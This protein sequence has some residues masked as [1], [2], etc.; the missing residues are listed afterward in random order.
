MAARIFVAKDSAA[1]AV[2]ADEVAE[3]VVTAGRDRGIALDVVRT[4]SRG[5]YW[6]EPMVEAETLAGRVA[7][8]PV[9][10]SDVD[11][12]FDAGFLDGGEHA[13]RLGETEEIPWLK[14]RRG[15]PFPVAASSIRC[16]SPNT[17]RT[18]A[19]GG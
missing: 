8:G 2:G 13:L 17:G 5:L 16:R 1:V 15:S 12:L 18:A 9:Q 11:A 19:P 4:G 3:A 6:A 7:Y 10:A 14:R